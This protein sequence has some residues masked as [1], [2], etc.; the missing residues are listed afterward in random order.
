MDRSND[1]RTLLKKLNGVGDISQNLAL[2]AK[3]NFSGKVSHDSNRNT[4]IC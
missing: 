1:E 2:F 4:S 3:E